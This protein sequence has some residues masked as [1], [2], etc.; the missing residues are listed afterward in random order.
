VSVRRSAG[1]DLAVR[2]SQR[3][4]YNPGVK[5]EKH[6]LSIRNLWGYGALGVGNG[7]SRLLHSYLV[8]FMKGAACVAASCC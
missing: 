6:C 4:L 1:Q 7:P 8:K 2:A 3:E 5:A